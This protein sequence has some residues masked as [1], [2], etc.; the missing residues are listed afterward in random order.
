MTAEAEKAPAM[1]VEILTIFPGYFESP[2]RESLL[3]KAIAETYTEA[4]AGEDH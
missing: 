1:H 2:L 4:R 3:G